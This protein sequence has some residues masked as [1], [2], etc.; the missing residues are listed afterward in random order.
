VQAQIES[1][2]ARLGACVVAVV[3]CGLAS[4][5]PGGTITTYQGCGGHGRPAQSTAGPDGEIWFTT[6]DANSVAHITTDDTRHRGP[7]MRAS[8]ATPSRPTGGRQGTAKP[9][10]KLG[11]C[12]GFRYGP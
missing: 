7:A 4:A 8:T 3:L 6:R 5:A 1:H 9:Q 10:T 12:R 2:S 11:L